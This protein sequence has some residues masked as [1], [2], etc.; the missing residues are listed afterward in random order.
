MRYCLFILLVFTIS[1]IG[2]PD[3]H[4]QI[5]KTEAAPPKTVWDSVYTEAQA[6]RGK[7]AYEAN[8]VSC[9]SSGP[10]TSENFMR[11]WSG[12]DLGGVFDQIKATMPADA[13]SSLNDRIYVDVLAYMLRADEF[14]SG[15]TELG[16]TSLKSIRV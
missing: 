11:N 8:C 12:T 6:D 2:V 15:K 10:P 14:P 3:G 1:G 16:Q 4:A 5:G 7:T 9:H 13:P